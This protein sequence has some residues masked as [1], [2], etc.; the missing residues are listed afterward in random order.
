MLSPRPLLLPAAGMAVLPVAGAALGQ[1]QAVADL[2]RPG[3]APR[4]YDRKVKLGLIGC[5]GRGMWISS[6]FAA[7][8]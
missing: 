5:G 4:T 6:L 7:Q 2:V 8:G 1:E 3:S